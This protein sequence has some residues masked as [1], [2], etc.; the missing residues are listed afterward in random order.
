MNMTPITHS[1]CLKCNGTLKPQENNRYKCEYCGQE[2]FNNEI[3]QYKKIVD[4]LTEHDQQMLANARKML[5]DA[6]VAKYVSKRVD[7]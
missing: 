6:L 4:A 5:Y 2:W 7:R 1:R 3:E